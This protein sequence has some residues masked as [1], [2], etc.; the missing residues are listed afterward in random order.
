M[1]CAPHTTYAKVASDAAAERQRSPGHVQHALWDRARRKRRLLHTRAGSH[2][3]RC[4]RV[5]LR[6]ER[7]VSGPDE[8]AA[9]A[10]RQSIWSSDPGWRGYLRV[11][12]EPA[13]TTS[14]QDG[15]IGPS[16]PDGLAQP[17]H[18]G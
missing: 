12:V 11:A 5:W 1:R 3:W 4:R 15:G 7:H 14:G 13:P 2:A 10:R 6:Q 9:A 18:D 8:Y 16:I 17:G